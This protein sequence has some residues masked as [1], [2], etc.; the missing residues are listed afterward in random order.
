M[1]E[2]R[3]FWPVPARI[4]CRDATELVPGD[5]APTLVGAGMPGRR[6]DA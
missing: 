4:G 1:A 2:T 5:A 6:R 3:S